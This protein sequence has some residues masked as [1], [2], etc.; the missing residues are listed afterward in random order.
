MTDRRLS[1]K[2]RN[3]QAFETDILPSLL[4][5]VIYAIPALMLMTEA[6]PADLWN[7]MLTPQ[8]LLNYLPENHQTSSTSSSAIVPGDHED[9]ATRQMD[10]AAYGSSCL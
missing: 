2:G 8:T 5:N 4:R 1:R 6:I 10:S 7:I 3:P 9:S